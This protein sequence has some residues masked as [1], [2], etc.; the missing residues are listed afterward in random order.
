MKKVV[1]EVLPGVFGKP[2]IFS[3]GKKVTV[4]GNLIHDLLA[5]A[6]FF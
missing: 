4:F 2:Q 3:S 6:K 1:G 5:V